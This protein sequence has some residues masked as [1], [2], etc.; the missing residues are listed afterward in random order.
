M[1]RVGEEVIIDW[2]GGDCDRPIATGRVYNGATQPRW[3]SN[4]ILS[5]FRSKEYGGGG[6]NQLVM[7]DATGQN[8][9]QLFSSQGSSMLHLGYLIAQDG[10]VRGSYLGSGFDL[11]TDAYGAIRA[12]RG[13]FLTTH[14]STGAAQQLEVREARQQLDGAHG[15]LEALSQASTTHQAEGLKAGL[16][17]LQ[18]FNKATVDQV[19]GPASGGRTAGGGRG[20]ANAFKKPVL[21]VSSPAGIG[22]STQQSAHLGAD[23]QVNM[24]SGQSTHLVAG[25]SLIASV[26]QRISLF[27]QNAGMKLFAAK[28]K[29]EI[30]AQSDNIELTAQ[31]TVKVLSAAEKVEV[32]ASKGILLTSGGAYIRIQDGNIEIH[33]PGK[34]DVKGAQHSFNGP[35]SGTYDLPALPKGDLHNKLELNLTDDNLKGVPNA[36]YKVVFE[37][38]TTMAGKLDGNGHAVL[39]DVPDGAAKVFFGEDARPFIPQAVPAAK[40]LAQPDILKEL[41]AGGHEG[42]TDENL[43]S[44]FNKFSGRPDVK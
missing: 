43:Y 25:K 41:H 9:M 22:L 23:E 38:G 44:L 3:H 40:D 35:T 24:V 39:R 2:V 30:Q 16:D 34:I 42:I 11:R 6:Y 13:L 28:G 18:S 15:L 4:G 36:P 5:G 8:R 27:V 26:A 14:S 10:N 37:N 33:V 1:P 21:L 20:A 31:K 19:D 32:A 17:T 29:V 7:D 12:N